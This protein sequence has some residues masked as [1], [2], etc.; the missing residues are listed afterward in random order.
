M[1]HITGGGLSENI[2]RMLPDSLAAELDAKTWPVLDVFK[3]LKEAGRLEDTEF[4]RTFNTGL[5]MVLVVS[6]EN[7]RS[8]TEILQEHGEQVYQIGRLSK[9]VSEECIVHNMDAWR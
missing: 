8:T 2:P 1:A 7:V 6:E 4:C 9:R 5:G 3:W